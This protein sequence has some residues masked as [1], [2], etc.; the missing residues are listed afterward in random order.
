VVLC[1]QEGLRC[2]VGCC[3]DRWDWGVG[4]GVGCQ[5]SNCGV[6]ILTVPTATNPLLNQR[7]ALQAAALSSADLAD[8]SRP[9][10][11]CAA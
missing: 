11:N 7:C 5:Y 10:H 2:G 8:S 4:C 6:G 9:D 3:V 1:G